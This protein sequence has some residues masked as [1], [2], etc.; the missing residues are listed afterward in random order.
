MHLLRTQ[1]RDLYTHSMCNT[2]VDAERGVFQN[3]LHSYLLLYLYVILPNLRQKYSFLGHIRDCQNRCFEQKIVNILI[4]SFNCTLIYFPPFS[5]RV[6]LPVHVISHSVSLRSR[7]T[8]YSSGNSAP[9]ASSKLILG[10]FYYRFCILFGL[11]SM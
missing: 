6:K 9:S 1:R 4:P 8:R 2:S 10:R 11:N 3:S 7:E 5:W